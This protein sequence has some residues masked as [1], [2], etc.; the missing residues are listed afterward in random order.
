LLGVAWA[1]LDR[2]LVDAALAIAGWLVIESTAAWLGGLQMP[3]ATATPAILPHTGADRIAWVAVAASVGLCEE[4]VYR[5]YFQAQITALAGPTLGIVLQ[6]VLFGIAH[7][8][9]GAAGAVRVMLYG[10]GF[11]VVA[12]WRRSLVPGIACHIAVD[13]AAGFL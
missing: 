9:Q 12:R 7:A 13:L 4:V 10:L 3:H 2:A 11:G 6:A 8:D 5:G 1:G